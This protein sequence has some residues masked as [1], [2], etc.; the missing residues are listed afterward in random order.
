MRI[1]WSPTAKNRLIE[2]LDYIS[3]D[4]AEAAIDL[5]DT[6][7]ESVSKIAQNP[8]IGRIIPEL[9][10]EHIREIVIHQNYGIIYEIKECTLEVLTVRHFRKSFSGTEF[11]DN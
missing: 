2:I 7:E 5:I 3:Q 9:Q 11:K 6:I 8:M 1:I 10:S 4:N